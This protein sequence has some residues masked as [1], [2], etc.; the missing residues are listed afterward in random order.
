LIPKIKRL[1]L[2]SGKWLTDLEIPREEKETII[3]ETRAWTNGIIVLSAG[4][5]RDDWSRG[6][7]RTYRLSCFAEPAGATN[8]SK[9]FQAEPEAGPPSA[10]L[11]SG[12]LPSESIP[13]IRH[14]SLLDGG[15]VLVCAGPRQAIM[16]IDR[17]TGVIQWS[18]G[19]IWEFERGFTGPSNW[20]HF[21][22]RFGDI[23]QRWKDH[24]DSGAS[25]AFEKE[26]TCQIVGG[27]IVLKAKRSK[28]W[29]RPDDTRIFVAVSKAQSEGTRGHWE[30]YLSDCVVYEFEGQGKP[31]SM[32]NLPRMVIGSQTITESNAVVWGLQ[33]NAV[34]R[35][36]VSDNYNS[37]FF[38]DLLTRVSWYKELP[39]ADPEAWLVTGKMGEPTAFA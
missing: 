14:I 20:Q 16:H 7:L 22:S 30:R 8:W 11:L 38:G 3:L 25:K 18:I 31:V 27:P 39:T 33:N 13:N 29:S 5:D 37:G 10:F 4:I 9:S 19:R 24:E 6:S 12:P 17:G 32:V 34:A 26:W 23:D 35:L 21:I 15:E 28:E 1:D 2:H 36:E